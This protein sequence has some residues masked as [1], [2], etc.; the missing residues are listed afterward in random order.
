MIQDWALG[1]VLFSIFKLIQGVIIIIE[2]EEHLSG[3]FYIFAH[4]LEI[5][6][7]FTIILVLLKWMF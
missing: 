4:Y 1:W 5:F 3:S 6:W 7:V 2:L